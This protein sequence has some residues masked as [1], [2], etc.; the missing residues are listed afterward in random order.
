MI[1][2]MKSSIKELENGRWGKTQKD[3]EMKKEKIMNYRATP[4]GP[5]SE[6]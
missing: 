3:N 4:R 6:K 5:K 1:A 2:K